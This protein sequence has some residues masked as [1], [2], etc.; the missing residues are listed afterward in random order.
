ME[1]DKQHITPFQSHARVLMAL[2]ILT[3]IT[4]VVAGFHFGAFSVG[5]A[6]LVASVKATIVLVFFM[7]LKFESTFMK[8]MVAGV[9]LLFALVI[10]ITFIDYLLR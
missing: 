8:I 4:V 2:L 1:H 6:L 3:T 9:F 7:H 10:I 5:V